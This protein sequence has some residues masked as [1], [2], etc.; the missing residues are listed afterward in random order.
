MTRPRV[1]CASPS[2]RAKMWTLPG[3][4]I[5]GPDVTIV[6]TWHNNLNFEADDQSAPK[7][8]EYWELDFAQIRQAD[9]LLAYAEHKDRP[10]GTLIEIGYA[11]AHDTP[12]ALVGNYQWGTWQH[13]PLVHHYPTIREAVV[14]ITGGNAPGGIPEGAF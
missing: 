9:V 10:N 14:A 3:A 11:L 5:L 1:Y 4:G 2:P 6:S 12:V 7:C 13:L 8:A